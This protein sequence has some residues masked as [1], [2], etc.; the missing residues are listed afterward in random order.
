MFHSFVS[1]IKITRDAD[2]VKPRVAFSSLSIVYIFQNIIVQSLITVAIILD[3][4]RDL[5]ILKAKVKD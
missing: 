1:Y 4:V 2:R 5:E 3:R